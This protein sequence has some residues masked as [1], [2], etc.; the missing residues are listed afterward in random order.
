[1]TLSELLRSIGHDPSAMNVVHDNAK[2][3]T[4]DLLESS[5]QFRR[6]RRS[7]RQL[8]NSAPPLRLQPTTPPP[9]RWDAMPFSPEHEKLYS[10]SVHN[11][12]IKGGTA[13]H[14]NNMTLNNFARLGAPPLSRAASTPTSDPEKS[15]W[16]E[17]TTSTTGSTTY[18]NTCSKPSYGNHAT[19]AIRKSCLPLQ[20]PTRRYSHEDT[21]SLL[22]RA[23]SEIDF[24]D[25]AMEE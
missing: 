6:L 25:D 21:A 12:C 2:C 23:L 17:K 5:S 19:S 14:H 16:G 1:M 15:Q 7:R 11:A 10:C 9:S 4:E 8:Q 18:R 24:S 3:P 13:T 22:Q 20:V